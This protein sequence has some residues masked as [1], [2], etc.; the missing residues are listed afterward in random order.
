M[1]V[2]TD[3]F[4][5]ADGALGANWTSGVGDFAVNTNRAAHSVNPSAAYY[6]A[7]TLGND[8]YA[9]CAVINAG[10]GAYS[11]VALRCSGTGA[12]FAAIGVRADNSVDVE[13][14]LFSGGVDTFQYGFATA[15][16]GTT[17]ILKAQV[18]GTTL[19]IY[20]NGVSID[21]RSLT[22]PPASGFAG[23]FSAHTGPDDWEGGDAGAAAFA[24]TQP[25][26]GMNAAV[27]RASFF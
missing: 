23:I 12:T 17:D 22:S 16:N 18:V 26:V 13:V 1:A 4:N 27:Y 2:F 21:S 25:L 8:Q 15:F 9:Q 11:G 10:S 6:S 20:K 14:H 24:A 7:G 3:N 19:T 5:R